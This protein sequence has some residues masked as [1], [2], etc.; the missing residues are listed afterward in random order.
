MVGAYQL[1]SVMVGDTEI[2]ARPVEWVELEHN[3][4][5]YDLEGEP[6]K[7]IAYQTTCPHCAQLISF[8][9]ED[10]KE[11]KVICPT[12]IIPPLSIPTPVVIDA[13]KS[14]KVQTR[15]LLDGV[16]FFIDP[17]ISSMP[18]IERVLDA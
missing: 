13:S 16:V 4:E 14:E 3:G 17:N 6:L 5:G 15:E 12:C 18:K 8:K 10:I 7:P 2:D 11:G 1:I 9:V